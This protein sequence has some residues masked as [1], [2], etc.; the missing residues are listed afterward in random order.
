MYLTSRYAGWGRNLW[1]NLDNGTVH[2]H[3]ANE[4]IHLTVHNGLVTQQVRQTKDQRSILKYG[5]SARTEKADK[6]TIEEF[7]EP[8]TLRAMKRASLWKRQTRVPLC[9]STGTVECYSTSSG[10]YG[11]EV[12]TYDNGRAG[13]IAARWR[14]RLEVSRPNGRP[15]IVIAGKV[16]LN[17]RCIAEKLQS[18]DGGLS[19]WSIVRAGDWSVTV[20][21]ADGKT[22]VTRGTVENRQKQGKWLEDGTTSYYLSGVKVSRQIYEDDPDNWD[23]YEVLQIKN[24]QIRCSLLNRMGYDK[25]LA[26]VDCTPIDRSDDGSELL[27]IDTKAEQR[28]FGGGPDR[29]MKL[30]KVICPSTGAVYVLRVPPAIETCRQAR[31]WGFGLR[32]AGIR[33]G[34]QLQLVKET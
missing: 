9:G 29:I 12:F 1:M 31:Q 14:K 20:Y 19:L 4:Y 30:V 15:W 6:T 13:Y 3:K 8:G 11:R 21:S 34:F 10:A 2:I 27:Q 25:L 22:I 26:K 5:H 17:W 7:F 23:G 16:C 32:E 33:Q 28:R 24:A 18:E